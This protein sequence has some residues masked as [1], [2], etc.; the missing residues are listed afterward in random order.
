MAKKLD[1]VRLD[2]CSSEG[3]E[4]AAHLEFEDGIT[5]SIVLNYE[6]ERSAVAAKLRILARNIECD[7]KLTIG[8]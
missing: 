3:G 2:T 4:Y 6:E 1:T 8:G 5:H 7:P